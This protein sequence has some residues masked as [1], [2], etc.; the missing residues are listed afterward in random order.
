MCN[1]FVGKGDTY[2]RPPKDPLPELGDRDGFKRVGRDFVIYIVRH[3]SLE[4][5]LPTEARNDLPDLPLVLSMPYIY[6]TYTQKIRLDESAKWH[7][8]LCHRLLVLQHYSARMRL[9]MKI[10][11]VDKA[12]LSRTTKDLVRSYEA[13][14]VFV[15]TVPDRALAPAA[16]RQID[17]MLM[18]LSMIF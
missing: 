2:I 1:D 18:P 4:M 9:A 6:E 14:K 10:R 17:M 13:L 16:T 15:Q 11:P 3:A 5:H 12:E 8:E 7:S